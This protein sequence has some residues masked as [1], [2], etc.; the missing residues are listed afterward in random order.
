MPNFESPIGSRKFSNQAMRELEVP[1][2]T[3][4]PNYPQQ[5]QRYNPVINESSIRDFQSRVEQTS[6]FE[7]ERE[8]MAAREARRT[9][10]E[11]L[12]EGAKKRIHLLLGMTQTTKE[13]NIENNSFVLRS[14]KSKE[15]RESLIAAA[16]YDGTVQAPYEIRR[17][18]LSRSLTYIA[19][20]EVE[21]FIGSNTLDAKLLFLDEL[22]ESLLAR[23]YDEYVTL[24]KEV[25]EKYN[26]KND[27]DVKE[28][29]DDIKKS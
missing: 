27:Q 29:V 26:I 14:L 2:E 28:V 21:Q 20:V 18:I 12:S 23:L 22:D 3:D 1:D 19:G 9:G 5:P 15:M 8:I 7:E 13:V 6:N 25:K 17:Q 4:A 16:E 24:A 10:R 11:K